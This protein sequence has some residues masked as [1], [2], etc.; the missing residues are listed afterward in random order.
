MLLY[1]Y[2]LFEKVATHHQNFD[3]DGNR[4]ANS[5][6]PRWI[7]A[8]VGVTILA[9]THWHTRSWI[10]GADCETDGARKRENIWEQQVTAKVHRGH[11]VDGTVWIGFFEAQEGSDQDATVQWRNRKVKEERCYNRRSMTAPTLVRWGSLWKS[12]S[13]RKYY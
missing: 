7:E 4:W 5:M 2:F 12:R 13:K 10:W 8:A 11:G 1:Y 9:S 6:I 3:R